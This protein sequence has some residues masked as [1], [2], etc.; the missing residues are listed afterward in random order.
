LF[1]N[2]VAEDYNNFFGVF[3]YA[4]NGA[5]VAIGD[6][7]ND[8]LSDIYFVGNQVEDKLYLNK[9]GFVF[10]DI[11]EKS[12]LKNKKAW[13]NGVVMADVNADGL[14]DIYITV[15]GWKENSESRKN[16][17]YINQGN[18]KFVEKANSYGIADDG[19]SL[20]SSFF[21]MDNDNDLDLIVTN[22]PQ[23]FYL[24]D[25]EV[26]EGKSNNLFSDKLYENNNGF[27]T[28][29]TSVK[30]IS[31]NF[32]YGLGLVTSDMDNNGYVDFFV[33]NDFSEND[34][35][36][37]NTSNGYF[38]EG[39]SKITNHL[40]YFTMGVDVVDFNNDGFEDLFTLDMSPEDYIR[41]KTTMASMNTDRY[42]FLIDNGFHNQYMN[43]AFH[44]NNG[45][46][47]FS[48]IAQMSEI[49]KTDWSWACL[50][51]DFDND[52][53]NDLFVTNG[54]KRDLWDKDATKKR[55]EY[56]S[57][58]IDAKK[59]PNQIIKD[60]V[61]FYPSTKLSNYMFD[62]IGNLKFINKSKEWGLDT[63]S[64]SN[65]AA[66]GDLDNDGDLDLV[67]NNIDDEAFIYKNNSDKIPNS[68]FLKLK[69]NGPKG[70]S[71]GLG[72]KITLFHNDSIQYQDFKT[73][74]G[75]LSSVE[76]KVHF[77][78]G[79]LRK[80]D[81]IKVKWLDGKSNTIFNVKVNQQLTVN[82]N[83]GKFIA[84]EQPKI[85]PVFV[86]VT[87]EVVLDSISHKENNYDDYKEQ[88]LLPHKLSTL[89]PALAVGDVN[90]DGLDDFYYGG[91][92][93]YSGK[94]M[95]QNGEG[96]F[97]HKSINAFEK[98]KIYEDVDAVFFDFDGDKDL[99]LY[100]VSGGNEH[101][102][103]DDYYMDRLYENINGSFV[104]NM[105]LPSMK[106]S[107]SKVIPLD[108]DN[109]GDID[110][111]VGTR[112]RPRKYPLPGSSYLLENIKGKFIDVTSKVAPLS[113]C[114]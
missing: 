14:L 93:G 90:A 37:K 106:S 7:N 15:G 59:T 41:S 26:L 38:E 35:F 52:G 51:A 87:K 102:E 77:G 33:G 104:R 101:I 111:F 65:G 32:G 96:K 43:N 88:I 4:Y 85:N 17:L 20:S 91:A 100:V 39:V 46:N 61:N 18:N 78:L 6:I 70:N 84:K 110:L 79:E 75:Y 29:V 83:E 53:D 12:G 30:G 23:K 92:N 69:L 71:N 103:G 72:A 48:E 49:A 105:S 114:K 81:S 80:V 1:N 19:F 55:D 24:T 89:G 57:K 11:T 66:Y 10:E 44:Y 34:Y 13:H 5:G 45:N 73:V 9:G 107:G 76:S 25:E 98:D 109:D 56:A 31:N 62:N 27:F 22:R 40:S 16:L 112:H 54:Y 97:I 86:N 94:L 74:R 67:V 50:G 108:F 60:I 47:F 2:K 82:Y 113:G 36:Y 68:N 42:K 21:D 64:F 95:L 28:D 63:P 58:P 3:N 99:D 8:G